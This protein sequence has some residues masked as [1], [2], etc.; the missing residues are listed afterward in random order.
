M[1]TEKTGNAFTMV[2]PQ[3]ANTSSSPKPTPMNRGA[4]PPEVGKAA[5][6]ALDRTGS[7]TV[8]L[9]PMPSHIHINSPKES[10]AMQDKQRKIAGKPGSGR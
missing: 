4:E 9:E 3:G 7:R 1:T 6:F 10:V 2:R 8:S 5:Q